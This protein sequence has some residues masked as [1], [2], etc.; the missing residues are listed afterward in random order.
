MLDGVQVWVIL[1]LDLMGNDTVHGYLFYSN[2][3]IN[4]WDFL[5]E[6]EGEEFER[7]PITVER[8]DE[9]EVDTYI[10]TLKSEMLDMCED[11]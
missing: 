5:D 2:N 4:H 11:K 1:E 3:L 9:L 8:Y 7:T 10:Y 6:F